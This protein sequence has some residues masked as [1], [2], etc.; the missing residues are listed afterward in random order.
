ML[1]FTLIG[2]KAK[3]RRH[4][5]MVALFKHRRD[6]SLVFLIKPCHIKK[7]FDT[8]ANMFVRVGNDCRISLVT[9]SDGNIFQESKETSWY[10]TMREE[11]NRQKIFTLDWFGNKLWSPKTFL[12]NDW[13]ENGFFN[14]LPKCIVFSTKLSKSIST[15]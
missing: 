9:N 4:S 2:F 1:G 14:T 3:V 6:N 13:T 8:P 5:P 10:K 7:T 11:Q 12:K 15:D